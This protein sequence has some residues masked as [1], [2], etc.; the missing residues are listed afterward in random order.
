MQLVK[1][2]NQEQFN[3]LK[4]GDL[5]VVVWKSSATEHRNGKEIAH[6]S[7]VEINRYNEII[8]RKRDNVYFNIGMFFR[9]ES[10]AAEAYALEHV[11]NTD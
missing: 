5:I 8:L 7:V 2:E 1:L 11:M 9:D 6:Y 4:K 3:K 10:H